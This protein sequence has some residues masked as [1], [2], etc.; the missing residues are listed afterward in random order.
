MTLVLHFSCV[1]QNPDRH[2]VR[3][4]VAKKASSA[5]AYGSL[6]L[7]A[8]FELNSALQSM[9]T[10]PIPLPHPDEIFAT[11][12]SSCY[13]CRTQAGVVI[14][15]QSIRTFLTDVNDREQQWRQFSVNHGTKVLRVYIV[16]DDSYP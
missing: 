11:V 2:H 1:A 8:L 15:T 5:P 10:N 6:H 16:P 3:F 14:D 13:E 4:S 7:E 9:S 12:R